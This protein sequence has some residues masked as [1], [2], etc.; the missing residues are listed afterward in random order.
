MLNQQ[1][2]SGR[3]GK[4]Y[5]NIQNP[6]TVRLSGQISQFIPE[7]KDADIIMLAGEDATFSVGS[8]LRPK[9][10]TPYKVNIISRLFGSNGMVVGYDLSLAQLN[11]SSIFAAPMLGGNRKLFL[12]DSN[13]VN[14]FIGT[15]EDQ[16]VICLLY[17]FSAEPL[18]YKFENALE[19]FRTF[20][21]KIDTDAYHTLY[22]FNIP[23]TSKSSYEKFIN[24]EYS[25]ID[26]IIKLKILDYHSF[27]MD[28]QTAK[29]LYKSNAL[30]Q[31]L[32]NKLD[33]SI[34]TE[35]ELHSKIR[36][37]LEIFNEDYYYTPKNLLESR[38]KFNVKIE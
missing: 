22:V 19:S 3:L 9:P 23:E 27:N 4:Y 26:D 11:L 36:P 12:W 8:I 34:P 35:Q 28:G 15:K 5:L 13:F 6:R 1:N 31:E 7:Y 16:D 2:Q 24:S 14:A 29:V 20:K 17:R 37:E 18:F 10:K 30:K 25:K 38:S 32:E 33:C 21:Y